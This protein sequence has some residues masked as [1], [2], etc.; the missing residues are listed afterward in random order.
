MN[1]R[2]RGAS[3]LAVLLLLPACGSDPSSDAAD[4]QARN[5]AQAWRTRPMDPPQGPSAT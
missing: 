5:E 3:A 4:A 2:I 1:I